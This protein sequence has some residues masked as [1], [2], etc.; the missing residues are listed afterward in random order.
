[1]TLLKYRCLRRSKVVPVAYNRNAGKL[2]SKKKHQQKRIYFNL[3]L[4]INQNSSY[5]SW[6]HHQLQHEDVNYS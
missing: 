3:Q 5:A 4:M 2:N 6:R 1:M